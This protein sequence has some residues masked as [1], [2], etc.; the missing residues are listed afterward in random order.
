MRISDLDLAVTSL[1]VATESNIHFC[2]R[3]RKKTSS[4][5]IIAI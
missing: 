3:E 2:Q 5:I 4:Y 1:T